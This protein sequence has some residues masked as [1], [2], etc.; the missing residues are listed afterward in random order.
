M[1]VERK[2]KREIS[3]HIQHI[4]DYP[5]TYRV[6]PRLSGHIHQEISIN[7]NRCKHFNMR[8]ATIKLIRDKFPN[9]FRRQKPTF[10]RKK[11][12]IRSLTEV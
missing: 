11:V 4:L 10:L 9:I 3:K 1:G 2:Q 6:C 8:I 7:P 12:N 5:V